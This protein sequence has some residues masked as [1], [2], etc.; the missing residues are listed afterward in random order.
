MCLRL[1]TGEI[2]EGSWVPGELTLSLPHVKWRHLAIRST[3]VPGMSF[4]RIPQIQSV[5]TN[6]P[7]APPPWTNYTFSFPSSQRTS[8]AADRHHLP[9]MDMQ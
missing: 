5:P 4:C 6:F 8:S 3:T 1:E 2:G 7:K 9:P